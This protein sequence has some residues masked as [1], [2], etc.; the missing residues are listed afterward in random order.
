MAIVYA[1]S[2]G[3]VG[4]PSRP[5]V[6]VR[7]VAGEPWDGDDPFVKARPDLFNVEPPFVRSTT[8]RKLPPIEQATAAPGEVRAVKRSPGRPRKK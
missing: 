4:D 2:T 5:G 7:T 3:G 8:V 1:N 6:V